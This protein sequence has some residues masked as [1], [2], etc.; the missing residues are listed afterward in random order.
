M[1]YFLFCCASLFSCIYNSL[2]FAINICR[3]FTLFFPIRFDLI[4]SFRIYYFFFSFLRGLT[5][6]THIYC[7]WVRECSELVFLLKREK[8]LKWKSKVFIYFFYW[9]KK[10][11]YNN[12][13]DDSEARQIEERVC[14]VSAEW[15]WFLD[16]E[17][18]DHNSV[19]DFYI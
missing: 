19:C 10:S 11:W 1:Y 2:Y 4:S 12:D 14:D 5:L 18:Y 13:D 16:C 17:N 6:Q 7:M 8:Y 3:I 15:K 9:A